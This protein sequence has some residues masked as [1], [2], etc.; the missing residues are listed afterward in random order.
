M[1]KTLFIISC[2]L[3][4]SH[5][6][7]QNYAK[8]AAL[9]S[10]ASQFTSDISSSTEG[11]IANLLDGDI[12]TFWA[13]GA[14]SDMAG[15]LAD[16]HYHYLQVDL[17][18]ACADVFFSMS[19][20][21]NWYLQ[22]PTALK[23]EAS[24]DSTQWTVV[25]E[26]VE[27]PY[28]T[29]HANYLY[30]MRE[31]R[32]DQPYRYLRFSFLSNINNDRKGKYPAAQLGEFQVYEGISETSL[33][34]PGGYTAL[35]S[36]YPLDFSNSS[37]KA[38][39]ITDAPANGKVV[40]TPVSRV[41]AN[42]GIIV[43]GAPGSYTIP[44]ADTANVDNITV[45]KIV[46]I[47]KDTN[48][49]A[50]NPA[51]L[52]HTGQFQSDFPSTSEGGTVD[53]R[54]SGLIDGA[55]DNRSASAWRTETTIPSKDKNPIAERQYHYLQIDLGTKMTDLTLKMQKS[56]S[57]P[58]VFPK[59]LDILA[60]N[61]I[62]GEWTTVSTA[63]TPTWSDVQSNDALHFDSAYRYLRLVIKK[64]HATKIVKPDGDNYPLFLLGEIQVC[65]NNCSTYVL[66][67]SKNGI[68]PLQGD[69][70]MQAG[71]A[72]VVLTND[73]AD[74]GKAQDQGFALEEKKATAIS[75]IVDKSKG[76]TRKYNL[77]GQIVSRPQGIYIV[78]GK[79]YVSK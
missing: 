67:S 57:W 2:M 58:T 72:F 10:E 75:A 30:A 73:E 40:L 65:A 41:P 61:D 35:C 56:R 6:Q 39:I 64:N 76:N 66:D 4:C 25:A 15:N 9:I 18:K 43:K 3:A 16:D 11:A 50:A 7:A 14:V 79:K 78:N 42:T 69:T 77:A 22:Y 17:G 13:T 21:R 45:N 68:Y 70:D 29:N 62:N 24:N 60:S 49:S 74:N 59:T 53:D 54:F 8:A 46:G 71:G 51:L 36:P 52:S 28:Q 38:Y 37:L 44:V 33:T 27:T 55:N 1:K 19:A 47:G 63:M 34:V 12:N 5:A 48:V 20:R 31:V 23:I 32:M 26:K